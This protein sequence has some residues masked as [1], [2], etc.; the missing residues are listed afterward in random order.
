MHCIERTET[1][2]R[3]ALQQGV[4]VRRIATDPVQGYI[5]FARA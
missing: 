2:L 4:R 5:E 3:A 1:K